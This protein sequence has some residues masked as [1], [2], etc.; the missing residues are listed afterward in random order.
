[1]SQI[2]YVFSSKRYMNVVD[3]L[4]SSRVTLS[5]IKDRKENALQ[6]SFR[7]FLGFMIFFLSAY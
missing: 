7:P 4:G 3:K 6:K 5:Y 1:M 2:P